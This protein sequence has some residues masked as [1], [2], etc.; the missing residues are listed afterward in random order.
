M[1]RQIHIITSTVMVV[2]GLALT[3]AIA[4]ATAPKTAQAPNLCQSAGAGYSEL[5]TID[6]PQ[7]RITICQKG[8]RYVYV[9]TQ[10]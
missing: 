9:T 1:N 4:G 7:Q 5:Y 8:S 10:K 3:Q 2:A 6:E